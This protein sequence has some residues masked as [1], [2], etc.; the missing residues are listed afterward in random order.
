MADKAPPVIR[1]GR[2]GLCHVCSGG[3]RPGTY[4]TRR[5]ERWIHLAC[6]SGA[7]AAPKWTRD[8]SPEARAYR[9]AAERGAAFLSRRRRAW[10]GGGGT[11]RG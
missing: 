5:D 2:A 11:R 9:A 8:D 10:H 1:A 4:I 3:W 7:R 6:R